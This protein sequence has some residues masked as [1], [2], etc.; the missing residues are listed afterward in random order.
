[1]TKVGIIQMNST[2][3]VEEN[4]QT[5]RTQTELLASKGANWVVTPENALMFSNRDDYLAHAEKLG[6]GPIQAQLASIAKMNQV[7][8]FIGSMPTIRNE[9]MY[10]TCVVFNDSGEV[11]CS[12]DKLHMFD[13]DVSDSQG[14]YRESDTFSAGERPV[15]LITPFGVVG[16]SICYDL[17]FPH[18]YSELRNMGAEIIIVPAAFTAVTGKAHWEVLLRA[19]AIETQCFVIGI[20][21]TGTHSRNR[22]TWG[23]SMV[24]N[25]WG[26]IVSCMADNPDVMMVEIDKTS[27]EKVRTAMPVVRHTRFGT[28]NKI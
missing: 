17:R 12:Y 26:E 13:A 1:M 9:N 20:A 7:W 3:S 16:L 27:L 24:V 25:P 10:S 4:L 14:A 21:Q 6:N 19:R 5:I 28:V 22:E 11:V 2:E 15:V 18:L 8:L 23:H